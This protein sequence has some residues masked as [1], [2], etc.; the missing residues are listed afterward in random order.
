MRTALVTAA[1]MALYCLLAIPHAWPASPPIGQATPQNDAVRDLAEKVGQHVGT[2]SL[3]RDLCSI[4]GPMGVLGWYC[5]ATT[6]KTLPA[7]DKQLERDRDAFLQAAATERDA[8]A[9]AI[10]TLVGEIK[11]QREALLEVTRKCQARP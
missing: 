10:E 5:W 7:K 9:K 11:A 4:L 2:E 6:A 8:H 1:S 3:I